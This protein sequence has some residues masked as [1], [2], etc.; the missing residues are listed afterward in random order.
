MN[1]NEL[2]ERVLE[3]QELTVALTGP[4]GET[5]HLELSIPDLRS[6]PRSV[7]GD[8]GPMYTVSVP[9]DRKIEVSIR[10]DPGQAS[11]RETLD[12][13]RLQIDSPMFA[14]VRWRTPLVMKLP[15]PERGVEFHLFYDT[16][17][18]PAKAEV[19]PLSGA[20]TGPVSYEVEIE[21]VED[22]ESDVLDFEAHHAS[23]LEAEMSQHV[24]G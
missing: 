14:K 7:W 4:W 5:A 16:E 13:A 24:F 17:G 23:R 10:P 20:E 21:R 9:A 22:E 18:R 19:V 6:A 1:T 11:K 3:R 8:W 12:L 2:I 15:M